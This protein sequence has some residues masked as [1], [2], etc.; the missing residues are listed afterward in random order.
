MPLQNLPAE[1]LIN[2]YVPRVFRL[3]YQSFQELLLGQVGL[4]VVLVQVSKDFLAPRIEPLNVITDD[5]FLLKIH[6]GD[7]E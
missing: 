5:I 6:F 3:S 4:T 1:Y 2:L 7:L